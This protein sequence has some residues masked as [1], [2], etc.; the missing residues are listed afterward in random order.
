M[1]ASPTPAVAVFDLN[2]EAGLR[3]R[4]TN[5]GATWMACS[6]PIASMA[7]TGQRRELLLG[8][9]DPATYLAQPHYLG[10][11]VG[12]FTNRIRQG[13][14]TVDGQ[15][16]Q[17]LVNNGQNQLHG[18]PDG[19]HRRV[20]TVLHHSAHSLRL[21]LHSPDGDQG[22]PGAVQAQAEFVLGLDLSIEVRFE[23]T[24]TA[25]CPVRLTQHAYFNLDGDRNGDTPSCLDHQLQ[26]RA[27]HWLPVDGE[28]LPQAELKPVEGTGFD[29][30]QPRR[31]RDAISS[32]PV[33]M[34]HRGFDH[35]LSLDAA[36][37]S[38]TAPAAELL[39]GDG[40]VRLQ[41][42]TDQPALQV[43]SGQALAGVRTRDGG[44]YCAHAGIAL[45]PQVPPD[46]M[47]H[48]VQPPL[49]PD[50]VL[51][52]GQVW[53]SVTRYAFSVAAVARV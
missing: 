7:A 14:F 4:V 45:E 28:C 44:A 51:R 5:L 19:F 21:G 22:F 9:A 31:L 27:S 50:C 39:S 10:A 17:L 43:Y 1:Q 24:T 46:C 30:R 42:T 53:R 35:S 15:P 49:W 2:N 41:I 23:A 8:Y 33:L 12:R 13:R 16:V 38:G 52:P 11:T 47:N 34:S 36:A 26:L 3:V 29:L 32:D 25:P 20:W 37:R 6:V 48:A 18:G 40:R